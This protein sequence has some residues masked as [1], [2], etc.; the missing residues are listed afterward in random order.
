VRHLASTMICII[1]IMLP[2]GA[3]TLSAYYTLRSGGQ[4]LIT[5]LFDSC[6]MWAFPVTIA[7]LL[8]RFTAISIIPLFAICQGIDGIRCLLGAYMIKK[9]KWINNLTV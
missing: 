6:F 1:A 5:F 4:A 9:G 7:F 2:V 3:F 8:S